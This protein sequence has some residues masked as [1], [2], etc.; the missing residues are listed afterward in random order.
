[1]VAI[2]A[3]RTELVTAT[4]MAKEQLA[5]TREA[6]AVTRETVAVKREI[7]TVS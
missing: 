2:A 3:E 7:V 6:V 5:V 4:K 1:M